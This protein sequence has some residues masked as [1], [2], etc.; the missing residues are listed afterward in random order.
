MNERDTRALLH[1]IVADSAPPTA[2]IDVDRAIVT[3]LRRRRRGHWLLIAA[4]AAV[5]LVMTVGLAAVVRPDSPRPAPLASAPSSFD[6]LHP[7]LEVGW[8]PDG[9]EEG[10]WNAAVTAEFV[11]AGT[12]KGDQSATVYA[13]PTKGGFPQ[14]EFFGE[15]TDGPDINGR[16]ST[17]HQL[18]VHDGEPLVYYDE[19][20]SPSPSPSPK[21]KRLQKNTGILRWYYADGGQVQ[22][23]VYGFKNAKDIAVKIARTVRLDDQRP[24]RMAAEFSR[25]RNIP[26][27]RTGGS[28]GGNTIVEFASPGWKTPSLIIGVGTART[29]P[30]PNKTVGGRK[31]REDLI[32]SSAI[33]EIPFGPGQEL[34][35]QCGA[36]DTTQA[37]KVINRDEC[38][39]VALSAKPVGTISDPTTWSDNPVR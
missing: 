14:A 7:R 5:V 6:P 23:E 39:R 33:L 31:V 20:A 12:R 8:Y 38:R 4:A 26:I 2:T 16:P 34:S 24:F 27:V 15:P 18:A 37:A 28:P 13:I 35:V 19:V 29:A 1:R 25:P 10:L 3:A 9:F 22:V 32:D 11:T 17:W 21:P 30:K 36:K